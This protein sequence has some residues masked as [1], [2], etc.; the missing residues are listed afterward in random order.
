M[1]ARKLVCFVIFCRLGANENDWHGASSSVIEQFMFLIFKM[2]ETH[3]I[4]F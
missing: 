2:D 4:L 1:R 3:K